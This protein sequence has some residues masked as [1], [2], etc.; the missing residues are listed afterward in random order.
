[1][2]DNTVQGDVQE[3]F[4]DLLFHVICSVK[5]HSRRRRFHESIN[6]VVLFWA[7]LYS[8]ST[9]SS[10]LDVI[11]VAYGSLTAIVTSVLLGITLVGRVGAKA[12]D[13]N[14]LKRRFIR[15]QQSMER[16][17][18]KMDET[19]IAKWR[20]KRLEIE[21]DEPPINR[22]VHAQ[23]YN[24]VLKSLKHIRDTEKRYVKIRLRHR[25]FGWITRAF[26]DSLKLSDPAQSVDAY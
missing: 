23:C 26:D 20:Q 15:L 10:L 9:I 19:K 24:E 18:E 2:T 22:V 1:M 25:V 8:A 12:N 13:H 17:R 7:F 16:G 14:D 11:G 4:K 21:S 3:K 6:N 5:Y